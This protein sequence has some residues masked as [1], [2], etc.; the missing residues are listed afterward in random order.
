MEKHVYVIALVGSG[1]S[2]SLGVPTMAS[3]VREFEHS[4]HF[5]T[6]RDLAERELFDQINV[7]EDRLGRDYVLR[8]Q[9]WFYLR[10][11]DPDSFDVEWTL[12]HLRDYR[13]FMPPM[14]LHLMSYDPF[15]IGAYLRDHSPTLTI[16]E[17]SAACLH[18]IKE[19][20]VELRA[21]LLAFLLGRCTSS[22]PAESLRDL[23]EPVFSAFQAFSYD[24]FTTNYDTLIEQYFAGTDIKVERGIDE[25]G[26]FDVSRLRSRTSD[27]RVVK[28]HGSVDLFISADEIRYEPHAEKSVLDGSPQAEACLIYPNAVE[29]STGRV[30][31]SMSEH[32]ESSLNEARAC[33]IIGHSLRDQ[34]I[35]QLLSVRSEQ[36]NA[37]R[38]CVI[39][40]HPDDV[41][42]RLPSRL[43]DSAI[44]IDRPLDRLRPSDLAAATRRVSECT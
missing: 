22:A 32:F 35:R 2:V 4:V 43:R 38:V 5:D 28:L 9:I 17:R 25:R 11:A 3:M 41:V 19:R 7:V 37:F 36:R 31:A 26:I 40:P 34:R 1:A 44:V 29:S 30:Y 39:D 10:K 27:P 33:F 12:S 18:A 42:K 13:S 21:L 24:V 15:I 8:Y 14:L 6:L 16:D 23:Y 20:T